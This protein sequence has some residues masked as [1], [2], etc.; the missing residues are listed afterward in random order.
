MLVTTCELVLEMPKCSPFA[1][2][3]AAKARLSADIGPIMPH[4][5]ARLPEARY[6]PNVPALTLQCDGHHVALWPQ[7][8]LVAGCAGEQEARDVLGPLLALINDTW[9]RC[10][11]IVP[12]HTGWEEMTALG[13]LKLL[14]N[15]NCRKCGEAACLPFAMKL[16]TRQV[17]IDAC[18]P[19]L[20]PGYAEQRRALL[21]ELL[22]RGYEVLT[23]AGG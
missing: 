11:E 6:L 14:P 10:A 19:L 3:A 2:K 9:D 7:E 18:Q 17:G 5:N 15:L 13:A 21:G 8:I 12:D 1:E 23:E 16:V 20:E 4:L 22:A